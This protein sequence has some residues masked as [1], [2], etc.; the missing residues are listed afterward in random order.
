MSALN[1]KTHARTNHTTETSRETAIG[2]FHSHA[3]AQKAI[4][5]LKQAGFNDDQIGIV[6][7]DREGSFEE[8]MEGNKAG[9]GAAAGAATGLGVGA[10]WGLGIAAGLLPAIGPVIAGGTL[11]A[12]AASAAGSAAAGGLVGALIG[13]GIP[14]EEAEYY[15]GQFEDG[16]TLVSVRCGESRY[17]EAHRILDGSNSF[18][19][20]RRE[21]DFAT[22]PQAQQRQSADGTMVAREEVLEVDKHERT[23]GDVEIR[24]EVHTE[25]ARV[26]VPVEREELVIERKPAHGEAAGPISGQAETERITLK[27]EVVDVDKKTIAKEEVAIG[28]RTVTDSQTVQAELKEEEIVVDDATRTATDRDRNL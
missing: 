10:L 23:V 25:T 16:R 3:E 6:S 13:L 11:A 24:K 27:E 8:Q 14:E 17:A 4:R 7:R 18:D 12:I 15:S 22:N 1:S 5:D 20:Q 19:F 28:K 21:T 2:V 9:E 26:E